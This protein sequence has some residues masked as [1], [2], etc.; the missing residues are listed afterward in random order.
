M[1]EILG[2][3]TARGGSKGVPRKNVR[4]LGGRP[5]IAWTLEAA[6]QCRSLT[7]LIVSTDDAEIADACRAC[8]VEVPF[9]RPASLAGDSTPH[10]D[11]VLH[12]LGW[13]A[14]EGGERPEWVVLL[15]PTSPFRAAE[16]I[17]S[18]VALARSSG[19]DGVVSV[20][21]THD[22]P[23]LT[24]GQ[25]DDGT[26]AD[27]APTNLKYARRQDLPKAYALN[28]AVFVYRTAAIIESDALPREGL[29]P[30]IMPPERSLE[31]DTPWDFHL[32]ELIAGDRARTNAPAIHGIQA[33]GGR[34]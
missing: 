16:D 4:P 15:Q 33:P 7:R 17:D 31:I 11:V 27:Y 32:A 26:L 29:R 1:S 13:L 10:V 14:D 9:V 28:G 20:V 8:D 25:A 23:C 2:L 24:F 18:A 12:A 22:H 34:A 30:W 3:V 21:E 5:L 6:K 19:A